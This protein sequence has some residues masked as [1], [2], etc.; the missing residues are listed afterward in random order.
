MKFLLKKS[1]L[2]LRLVILKAGRVS[3]PTLAEV[4]SEIGSGR[5]ISAESN[6]YVY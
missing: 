3:D 1:S 4:A 2:Q 6:C 5:F